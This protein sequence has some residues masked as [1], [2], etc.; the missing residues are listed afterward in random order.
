MPIKQGNIYHRFR[1]KKTNITLSHSIVWYVY[2][3][4]RHNI[5]SPIP[6]HFL[7]LIKSFIRFLQTDTDESP[8]VGLNF[9]LRI[10]IDIAPIRNSATPRH[11]LSC[12]NFLTV[13]RVPPQFR[14]FAFGLPKVGWPTIIIIWNEPTHNKNSR[15]HF[16]DSTVNTCQ[17]FVKK[18]A[19]AQSGSRAETF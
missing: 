17:P 18:N 5:Q 9:L 10:H 6:R 16:N 19:P 15:W 13:T 7:K 12:R 11:K 4:V 14:P 3:S 2:D 1:K 8:S